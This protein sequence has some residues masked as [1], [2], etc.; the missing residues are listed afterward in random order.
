MVVR[1]QFNKKGV[2]MFCDDTINDI[3]NALNTEEENA[4]NEFNF[5]ITIGNRE[6]II[7]CEAQNYEILT[8]AL[9]EAEKQFNFS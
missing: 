4:V 7:P 9:K 3:M 8:E 2:E 6:I 5:Y 1:Y